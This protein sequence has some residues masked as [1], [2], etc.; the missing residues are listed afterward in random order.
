MTLDKTKLEIIAALADA[1]EKVAGASWYD[2]EQIEKA[3]EGAYDYR[4]VMAPKGKICDTLNASYLFDPT[5]RYSLMAYVATVDPETVNAMLR[6][7]A[8]Q[9]AIVA[10][11][12][13]MMTPQQPDRDTA[14][15]ALRAAL[16]NAGELPPA[17]VVIGK[18]PVILYFR[19]ETDR[20]D[21]VDE[22]KGA[23]D[24]PVEIDLP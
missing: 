14:A 2:D 24:H 5:D 19:T 16:Q 4:Q 21:F 22:A 3:G 1:A 8:R 13:A 20:E 17:S 7:I 15:R 12:K 6:L 18:F 10:A 9:G 23:M 11:A